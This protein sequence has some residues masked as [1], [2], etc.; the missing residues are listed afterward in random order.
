MWLFK[1]EEETLVVMG[2]F[3]MLAVPYACDKIIQKVTQDTNTDRKGN[4]DSIDGFCQCQLL[5]CAFM[6]K[7]RLDRE[8]TRQ[9]GHTER[10]L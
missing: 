3:Q 4:T 10:C 9:Y 8:H 6:K 7:K 5:G 1:G 2:E